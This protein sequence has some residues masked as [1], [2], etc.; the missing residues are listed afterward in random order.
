MHI[1]IYN[2]NWVPNDL[3]VMYANPHS[4]AQWFSILGKKV[5]E[6]EKLVR[7]DETH[8]EFSFFDCSTYNDSSY[9]VC[10]KNS[11]AFQIQINDSYRR[12][13]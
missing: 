4:P 7:V 2:K 8:S 6:I 9:T 3:E 5:S 12:E 10:I 11:I 13:L 1:K